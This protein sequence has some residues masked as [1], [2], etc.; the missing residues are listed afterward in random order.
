MSK[1]RTLHLK[2]LKKFFTSNLMGTLYETN[3]AVTIILLAE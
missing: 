1:F 3:K 2:E